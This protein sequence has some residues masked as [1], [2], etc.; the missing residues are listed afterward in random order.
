MRRLVVDS[1]RYWAIEMGVDGFRFDLASVFMR[2][3]E[4]NLNYHDPAIISAISAD[5][6]LAGV[7]LIAEPWQGEPGGGY[8]LGRAFSG[9]TWQQWNGKFRDGVRRFVKGDGGLVPSIMT[10]LHGSTDLFPGD[11]ANSFRPSQSI[12]FVTC[13]DGFTL[14]DLVSYSSD[15]QDSW[16]CDGRAGRGA[17]GGGASAQ[18]IDQEFL[19]PSDAVER[20]ADVCR[21]RRVHEH[22]ARQR[23]SIQ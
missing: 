5:E 8:V 15:E 4:G 22:A 9:L 2:D 19:L 16:N 3:D 13:H 7:R 20:G 21:R 14:Y 12:N 23:Q 11:R 10:R 6:T 18:A 17:A 1:L